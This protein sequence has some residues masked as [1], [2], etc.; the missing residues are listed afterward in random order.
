M[1]FNT[2]IVP[3][4]LK[5]ANVVPIYKASDNS[6]L[7]NYRPISLLS[8]FSKLL[9]NNMFDKVINILNKNNI[10]YEHQY[11]FRAKYSTIQL[12]GMFGFAIICQIENNLLIIK[13][14]SPVYLL[15]ILC[16]VPQGSILGPLLYLL[17]SNNIG[18]ASE[19]EILSFADDTTLI[20]SDPDLQ[21]LYEK[22]NVEINK[23]YT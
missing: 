2:G 17:Y 15:D 12:H 19:C 18:N 1:S 21:C 20:L 23:W 4:Q 16:G 5:I 3:D 9:E 11:G 8:I 6:L 14:P 10:L 7:N 13:I 22:T